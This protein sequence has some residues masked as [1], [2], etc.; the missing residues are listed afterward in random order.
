MIRAIVV[1]DEPLARRY[2]SALLTRTGR[3]E[4]VGEAGD[5]RSLL[6]AL[7]ETRPDVVFLDIRM[8]GPSGLTLAGA[9]QRLAHPPLVVFVT[10]F[11]SHALEAFGVHA[12]DYLL[13]P[14]EWQRVAES[15]SYLEQ[16]LCERE[17]AGLVDRHA[18]EPVNEG[19]RLPVRTPDP[20]VSYLLPRDEVV[21]VLRQGRRT[22]IHTQTAEYYSYCPLSRVEAWLGGAPFIRAARHALVN[23]S[24]VK[25]IVHFGDRLYQLHVM[26]RKHTAVQVS[27]SCVR[28]LT[29]Y[30]KPSL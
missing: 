29:P 20:D 1:D 22:W 24:C 8:P 27:R 23:M 9:F 3:V 6:Q 17:A 14:L 13:K 2:L 28:H 19:D 7:Q 25:E 21:V 11:P 12:A 26:D 15:V 4:V 18:E 5:G 16:R 10:G 30:L